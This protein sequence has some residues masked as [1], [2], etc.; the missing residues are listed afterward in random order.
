MDR[1]HDSA[2]LIELGEASVETKGVQGLF[3]DEVAN[4][5][6]TSGLSDD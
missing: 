4:L 5:I 6:E 2:E 3:L 1:E